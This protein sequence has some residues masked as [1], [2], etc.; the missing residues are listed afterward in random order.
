MFFRYK[1]LWV[2]GATN[3]DLF[4]FCCECLHGLYIVASVAMT[5]SF[6]RI[7]TDGGCS[8]HSPKLILIMSKGMVAWISLSISQKEAF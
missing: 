4:A 6:I 3:S 5:L 2:H 1:F 7:V 8:L